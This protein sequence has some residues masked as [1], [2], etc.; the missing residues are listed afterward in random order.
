MNGFASIFTRQGAS[1]VVLARKVANMLGYL[2][3]KVQREDD[4]SVLSQADYV[5]TDK[6]SYVAFGST[7]GSRKSWS[8]SQDEG[9]VLIFYGELYNAE[10]LSQQISSKSLNCRLESDSDIVLNLFVLYDIDAFACLS[11][12]W[13]LIVIDFT[14]Q[15]LH[16]AIDK[17]GCCPL[18]Y[19]FSD[20]CIFFSTAL[21]SL[22]KNLNKHQ[23]IDEQALHTFLFYGKRN[24]FI[25]K[26]IHVIPMGSYI[27]YSFENNDITIQSYYTLS[28]KNCKAGYNQYEEQLRF[29]NIRSLIFGAIQ[30]SLRHHSNIAAIFDGTMEN[31]MLICAAKKICAD[32]NITVF[33][34]NLEQSATTLTT[35]NAIRQS[36]VKWI[37]LPSDF[38]FYMSD[39]QRIFQKQT[40]PMWDVGMCFRAHLLQTIYNQGFSAILCT[41]G[42]REMFGGYSSCFLPFLKA[43][44]SQ[45]MF[46]SWFM[47]LLKSKK[48]GMSIRN[49]FSLMF[50]DW[51]YLYFTQKQAT[52]SRKLQIYRQFLK[53][54]ISND[55]STDF[56]LRRIEVLNDY[57][58]SLYD[59]F[60]S[61][62]CQYQHVISTLTH[63]TLLM[64]FADDEML[65]EYVFAT[66]STLKIHNGYDSYL[67]RNAM[68]GIV[69]DE[70]RKMKNHW[71]KVNYW[72]F[73]CAFLKD[74][75]LKSDIATDVDPLRIIL[76][77]K[78]V[79]NWEQY[80][81]HNNVDFKEFVF[82][83][84]AYL[85]WGKQNV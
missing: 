15:R 54:Q 20:H 68:V 66:P 21:L 59:N 62:K 2:S 50:E 64:P 82:R 57:L 9:L 63:T 40:L 47:E 78:L 56:S 35:A 76:Q 84:W 31:A 11:G 19:S 24:C 4:I 80:F 71:R 27:T 58:Y 18:Y 65:A 85:Q 43:L 46:A 13:S 1:S 53:K 17:F 38:G 7:D 30:K 51:D 79:Q 77:E 26:S 33:N 61:E 36:G 55:F 39:F 29:D 45:W 70:V 16:A 25:F 28:Y 49:F 74:Q 6:E 32:V 48:S 73:A 83:Y 44:R 37:N 12:K 10:E 60:L 42:V 5:A 22:L 41:D 3:N 23:E 52:A 69:N 81:T 72:K 8:K 34:L 75:Q 67:L 14:N